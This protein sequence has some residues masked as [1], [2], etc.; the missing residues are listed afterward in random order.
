MSMAIKLGR[1]VIYLDG[2]LPIKSPGPL[3]MRLCKIGWRTKIVISS[4]PE[5]LWSPDIAGW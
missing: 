2:L 3:I 4:L 5:C 1:M